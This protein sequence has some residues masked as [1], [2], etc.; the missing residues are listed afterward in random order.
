VFQ[1]TALIPHWEFTA[2]ESGS[3]HL[4]LSLVV[5]TSAAQARK[6]LEM[7]VPALAVTGQES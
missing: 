4:R 7:P 2:P 6:L 1:S 3:V 5:D